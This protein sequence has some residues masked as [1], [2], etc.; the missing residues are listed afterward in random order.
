MCFSDND[1]KLWDEDPH[2]YVRKGYD[3]IEDLYSPRITAMDNVSKLVRKWGKENLQKL[4]LFIVEIFKRYEEA[5]PE[6]KPCRQKDGTLL[7]IG[8][9]C[10]K[11]KNTKPYKSGLEHPNN[12]RKALHNVVTGMRDPDLHV[13][14]EFFELMNEVEIEYLVFTLETI[15][16]KFGEEMAPYALGLC[17]N[18]AA[19]FWKCINMAEADE[20]GDDPGAFAAVGCLR[21]ISTILE[22]MREALERVS[23]ENLDLL[24]AN[25]DQVAEA[26]KENEAED[27]D[28]MNGLQTDEDD[29]EEDVT[30]WILS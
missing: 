23:K 29:D 19:A 10:D 2:E 20:E 21:A 30:L 26:A 14:D 3:I 11:L 7:I 16:D 17:Q 25:K 22:S 24:V 15:V 6:Y 1:Q 28:D 4:I 13:L 18:L 9:L 12:F 5:S 27:N 8:A